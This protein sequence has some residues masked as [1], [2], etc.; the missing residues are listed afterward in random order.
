M[1]E[2]RQH[3]TE[4]IIATG[5][6]AV[7]RL[8]DPKKMARVIEALVAGGIPCIEITMTVPRAIDLIR[9][10]AET[11]GE[12]ILLGVGSVLD[13]LTAQQAIDAGARFV[14]S[15]IYNPD[16][17]DAAHAANLPA[18]PGAFSPTEI[19]TAY[20]H[21]ADI[22]KVFPADIVGMSYF[23]SVRAPMPHLKLMPTGGVSLTNA[24][25]WM[26]AGACA[27]G[28]GSALVDK[29]AIAEERYDVLEQNARTLRNTID[30]YR[31]E[32]EA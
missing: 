32:A 25:E 15:P 18:L 27:V 31:R 22:V 29:K 13:G 3:I 19:Q 11:F 8:P 23:K 16:V 2:Q 14:V 4:Q 26:A 30:A 21:G 20:A 24:G 5:A 1:S 28:V 12:T 7:V 6:A 10:A 17:V 9:E